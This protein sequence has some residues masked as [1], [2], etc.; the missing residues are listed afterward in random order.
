MKVVILCG[1][2]GT[3]LREETEFRPKPLID[4]GGKPIIWHIM[5]HFAHY[6]L[7]NFVLCL[8]YKGNM[9]KEYFLSYE[10][11][12]NDFTIC[13]GA[14]NR[15]AYHNAHLE[16][17]FRVTLS[18]TGLESMTGARV[19]RV[20]KYIDDDVFM[21]TYGDGLSDINISKLLEYHRSHGRL[22]TVSTVRNIS[23]FGLLEI[24]EHAGVRGF[25]EKPQTGDWISAGFF[26]FQREAFDYLDADPSCVLEK[27]PLEQ[28]ARDG[29]LMAYQHDG[30]FHAMDTYR[31]YLYLN[32]LWNDNAAPWAVWN[33]KNEPN[34]EHQEPLLTT[35]HVRVTG[36]LA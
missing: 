5:K 15:I 29:Q 18:D 35:H 16:Q 13:L 19:K 30:F 33:R 23:R 2:Q 12:N 8:G 26:V 17:D 6:G 22:A 32:E 14:K 31:E 7:T 3:R 10:A 28:L 25:A 36:I 1:G 9:F 11:M 21:V 4:I 27:E 20:Q 34:D 24:D